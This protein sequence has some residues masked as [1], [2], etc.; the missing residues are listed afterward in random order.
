MA[1]EQLKAMA[2]EYPPSEPDALLEL[3]ARYRRRSEQE[4]L[5]LAAIAADVSIAD[6]WNLGL[7][8]IPDSHLAETL[9]RL[10]YS[11]ESFSSLGDLT[12]SQLRGHVSRVKGTYFEVLVRERLN[13][14]E[15][16]GGVRLLPGQVAELAERT[17]QAGW[18]LRIHDQAGNVVEYMQ[19]KA[20]ES[21]SYA[22]EALEKHPNI[23]VITTKEL[24]NQAADMDTVLVSGVSSADLEAEVE[25][26]LSEFSEDAVTDIL[27]Q[28][29]EAG[30]DAIP[31][32]S[33]VLIGFTETG[34]V[35][36][37]RSTVEESLR[38]GG[39]RLL[40]STAYT[41]IGLALTAAGAGAIS[42]PTAVALRVAGGR[43]RRR[44]AMGDHL[45][46]KTWEILH[47]LRATLQPTGAID[48]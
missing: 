9:A 24:E 41:A 32:A 15:S 46:E 8:P 19:L 27:H 38:R 1:Y 29:T 5:E 16:V 35:L 47:E 22:K 40:S 43:T 37:G 30:F 6:I 7:E 14:G 12:E 34:Q 28:G 18:D 23:P 3:A 42:V 33:L 26:Q 21:V 2:A 44:R 17:N 36:V 13:A 48:P 25:K 10:G 31:F 11:K 39:A 20:A 45:E 4:V